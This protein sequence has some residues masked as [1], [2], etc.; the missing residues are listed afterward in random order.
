MRSAPAPSTAR[1]LSPPEL[2]L[3]LVGFGHWGPN[4]AKSVAQ[5]DGA[6]LVWC[7]DVSPQALERARALHPGLRT[8]TDVDELAR[9]DD[10]DAVI[11]TVPPTRHFEIA[12]RIVRAGKPLLVEK[13]L[14]DDP[15]T[16][17]VL[18]REA[19]AAGVVAMAGHVYLFNPAVT[20]IVERIRSGALGQLRLITAER[21][22]TRLGASAERPDVDAVWDL[23]PNDL[24]MFVAFA[25]AWPSRV[26]VAGGRH[27]RDDQADAAFV[28]LEFPGGAIA[29]LRLAWDYPT[30][31]RRATIVG[32]AETIVFDDDAPQKL[33][34]VSG[35]GARPR[36]LPY[37]TVSPLV[38]QLGEF[39]R[40]VGER[41]QP[42][43]D[44]AYGARM[45]RLLADLQAAAAS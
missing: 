40:C 21:M 24:A 17:L 39:V 12:R 6:R 45:V 8:T 43:N 27:A 30:R 7:A 36:P 44:F 11:V 4:Y 13:P 41:R 38:A 26:H 32:S 2:R 15:Q 3:G 9:A 10:C 14:T 35:D 5:V 18:E 34:V 37:A 20:A 25:G 16:A 1:A 19:A 42:A 33:T 22:S 23:A 31:E 29:D 28:L